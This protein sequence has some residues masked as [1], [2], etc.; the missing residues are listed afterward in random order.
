[1]SWEKNYLMIGKVRENISDKNLTTYLPF[2][3][4]SK[5]RETGELKTSDIH[6]P[7][8]IPNDWIR[9]GIWH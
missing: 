3:V 5:T 1:M 8:P 7:N 2:G 9:L 6:E 4:K